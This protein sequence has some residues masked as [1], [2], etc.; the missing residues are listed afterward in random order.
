MLP[1]DHLALT[2]RPR[3][4]HAHRDADVRRSIDQP[5]EGEDV[6]PFP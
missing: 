2:I 6:V 5:V 1:T 3:R 4:R